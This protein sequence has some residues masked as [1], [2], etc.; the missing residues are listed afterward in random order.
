MNFAEILIQWYQEN[1]RSLPWRATNDAYKIWVSE[2]ILQQTRVEQGLDYYF[3]FIKAFPDIYSLAGAKEYDVLKLWQGLGYY[4]RAR[5]MLLAARQITSDYGGIIPGEM[6]EIIKI[7]GI[8]EYTAAAVLSFAFNKPFPVLDGNVKRILSRI[9]GIMDD[10]NSVKTKK[11]MFDLLEKLIDKKQPAVFNQAIMDFGALQCKP[12][13]P[14]CHHCVFRNIC[15][16]CQNNLVRNL[17]VKSKKTYRTSRYLNYIVPIIKIKKDFYTLMLKRNNNDI[18]K[19]LFE[20][21]L[22]ET[23]TPDIPEISKVLKEI[24]LI[25]S[26]HQAIIEKITDYKLTHRNIH[27][28]FVIISSEG[29]IKK[30]DKNLVLLDDIRKQPVSRLIELFLIKTDYLITAKQKW[31]Y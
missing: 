8:G 18:W 19:N 13:T 24:F 5:N 11:I 14:S 23:K 6:K 2:I 21:P 9:Y 28:N 25:N 30:Y 12:G 27:A 29:V 16:A 22:I 26:K 1:K 4:S 10:V 3:R 7:K 17:P 20:F 15:Y 31:F